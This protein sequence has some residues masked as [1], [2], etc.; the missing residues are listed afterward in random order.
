MEEKLQKA[1][2][3]I[4]REDAQLRRQVELEEKRVAREASKAVREKERAEKATNRAA[5]I[6]AQTLRKR[7][8]KPKRVSARLYKQ[9]LQAASGRNELWARQLVLKFV[10]CLAR[11]SIC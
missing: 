11:I 10:T 5:N 1:R 9:S 6:A 7:Y 2:A 8:N 3:K 4:E